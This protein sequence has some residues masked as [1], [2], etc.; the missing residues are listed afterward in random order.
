MYDLGLKEPTPIQSEAWPV[1]LERKD[2]IGVAETGSGKTLA[3][4]LP[5]IV[6]AYEK[7]LTG[8]AADEAKKV[9]NSK[10]SVE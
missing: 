8:E 2:L 4:L 6:H 7:T 10:K 1:L 3:F 9:F 5:S